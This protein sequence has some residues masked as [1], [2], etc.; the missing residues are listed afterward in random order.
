MGALRRTEKTISLL[1]AVAA[2]SFGVLAS[3]L[4]VWNLTA[5]RNWPRVYAVVDDVTAHPFEGNKYA[6]FV[7][8]LHYFADHRARPVS[9]FRSFVFEWRGARFLRQYAP[10]TGHPVWLNPG[11]PDVVELDLGWNAE[12]L[13]LPLVTGAISLLLLFSARRHWRSP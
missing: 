4:T 11:H 8:R 6:N 5:Y 7:L 9:A 12:G 2:L 1:L 10:G 13:F 3:G